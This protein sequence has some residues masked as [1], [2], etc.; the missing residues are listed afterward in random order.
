VDLLN[1]GKNVIMKISFENQKTDKVDLS[2]FLQASNYNETQTT[3]TPTN[4]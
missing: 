4:W 3:D 2:F 1:Q